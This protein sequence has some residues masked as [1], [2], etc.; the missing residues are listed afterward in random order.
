M[1]RGKLVDRMEEFMKEDILMIK[2]MDK[3]FF[4]DL[5]ERNIMADF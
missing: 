3:E 5:M 1:A 2:K 4:I